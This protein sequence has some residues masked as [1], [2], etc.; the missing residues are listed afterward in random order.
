MENEDEIRLRALPGIMEMEHRM[1]SGRS[2]KIAE[3]QRENE[4]AFKR[5]SELQK[6][7]IALLKK[8]N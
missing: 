2:D 1:I 4:G 6:E 8:T 7:E 5:V 3:L